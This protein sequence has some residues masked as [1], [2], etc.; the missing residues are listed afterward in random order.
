MDKVYV[1]LAVD[2]DLD[3]DGY[4]FSQLDYGIV[5]INNDLEELK[6]DAINNI[7]DYYE[8]VIGRYGV[9]REI[10]L[11]SMYPFQQLSK[12]SHIYGW[13]DDYESFVE[14]EITPEDEEHA[15]II[16]ELLLSVFN[17]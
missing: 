3:V 10:G 7:G 6:E 2:V 8:G 12:E 4:V 14:Q 16:K 13:N 17:N 9:I 5:E 11:G 15:V 1:L